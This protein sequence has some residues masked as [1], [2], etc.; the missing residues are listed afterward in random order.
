MPP[1]FYSRPILKND[2]T[3]PITLIAFLIV[4]ALG[5]WLVIQTWF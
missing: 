5:G 3:H 2:I 4:L 1:S